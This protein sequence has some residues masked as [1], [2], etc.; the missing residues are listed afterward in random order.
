M[1]VG[2]FF[3]VRVQMYNTYIILLKIQ[4]KAIHML[5]KISPNITDRMV[6]KTMG[7]I[8]LDIEGPFQL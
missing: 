4:K 1:W 6:T 3:L 8:V 7:N 2:V 5:P